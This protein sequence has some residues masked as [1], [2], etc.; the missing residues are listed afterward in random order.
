MEIRYWYHVYGLSLGSNRPISYLVETAPALVDVQ[1]EFLEGDVSPFSSPQIDWQPYPIAPQY[2]D[3]KLDIWKA[4]WETTEII[5][6]RFHHTSHP[7]DF[8]MDKEGSR[9]WV[10]NRFNTPEA[11]IHALLIGVVLGSLLRRRG[12]TCLHGSAVT[13]NG[14]AVLLLGEAGSGKSTLAASLLGCGFQLLTDDIAVIHAQDQDLWVEAGYPSLRIIDTTL[15]FFGYD[16]ATLPSVLHGAGN[17]HYL[18]WI[19]DE[20]ATLFRLS[21]QTLKAIY[22]L[23]P[24]STSCEFPSIQPL[25]AAEAV[26]ALAKQH[27]AGFMMDK[28]AHIR[29]FRL[30]GELAK[31]IPIRVLY[32]PDSLEKLQQISQLI[33]NDVS[34]ILCDRTNTV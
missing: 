8:T 27:Y 14:A 29:E 21:P 12:E 1:I 23:A 33:V 10:Q 16:V 25:V 34:N 15:A 9:I 11:D 28:M 2:L 5:L 19:S 7:I 20:P 32:R 31:K 26:A 13:S 4:K 30:L 3:L 22:I 17:K 18:S 6:R 24:R